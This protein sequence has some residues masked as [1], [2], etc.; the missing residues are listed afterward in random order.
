LN[1][2][3]ERI[4]RQQA[5]NAH[6]LSIL[7]SHLTIVDRES[8]ERSSKEFAPPVHPRAEIFKQMQPLVDLRSNRNLGQERSEQWD[9][10]ITPRLP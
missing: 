5:I 1:A 6:I 4:R 3:V 2:I 7:G 9:G 10:Q 8:E